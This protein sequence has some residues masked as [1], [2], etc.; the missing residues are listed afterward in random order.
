MM[1]TGRST[2]EAWKFR[3][4][5]ARLRTLLVEATLLAAIVVGAL[6][7]LPHQQEVNILGDLLF[8]GS[9]FWSAFTLC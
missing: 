1:E 7:F 9:T 6:G 3:S 5:T 2:R 8:L 4:A